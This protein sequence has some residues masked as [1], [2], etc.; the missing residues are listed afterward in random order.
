[1]VRG[2]DLF[3]ACQPEKP[4]VHKLADWLEAAQLDAHETPQELYEK[5]LAEDTLVIYTESTRMMDVVKTFMAAYPGLTVS[6]RDV[7]GNDIVDMLNENFITGNY[8]CDVVLRNDNDGI[9]SHDF[10]PRGVISSTH[11][12]TLRRIYC[13]A[14]TR[15][16]SA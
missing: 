3:S 16:H 13:R 2:T 10:I 6:V 4:P 7:R 8:A 1:M 15:E 9:L 14:V 5:V 12:T 11:P